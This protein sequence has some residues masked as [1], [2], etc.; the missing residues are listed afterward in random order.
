MDDYG[1]HPTAIRATLQGLKEFHPSRRLVVD[2]MPHTFSRTAALLEDFATAF[3]DADLLILHG[4]YASAREVFDG[5]ISGRDLF[6]RVSSRRGG[7]T[8]YYEAVEEALEWISG[9]IRPGDLF[10]TLGA[11]NNW[12]LG[13]ALIKKR[14][15]Q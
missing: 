5:K 10:L 14:E 4:I 12:S 1:H 7:R 6:E 15:V 8:V 13:P 3:D 11:G 2:F 9:E